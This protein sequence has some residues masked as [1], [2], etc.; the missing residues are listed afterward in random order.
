[1]LLVIGP[2]LYLVTELSSFAEF[3]PSIVEDT[4]LKEPVQFSEETQVKG[5]DIL[6]SRDSPHFL[7]YCLVSWSQ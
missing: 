2:L 1:M 6:L 7:K 3:G 4:L 5:G